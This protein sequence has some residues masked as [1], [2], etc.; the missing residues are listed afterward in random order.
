V[1]VDLPA[2][3]A[4]KD[5]T[6]KNCLNFLVEN[7][8]IRLQRFEQE[9]RQEE[10]MSTQLGA[11]CLASSL[12]PD[13]GIVVYKELQKARRCFV[14]ESDLHVLYQVTPIY[15]SDTLRDLSWLE[16]LNMWNDLGAGE[17]Y[18]GS[19]V[20][21]DEAFIFRAMTGTYSKRNSALAGRFSVHQR[22]YIALALND[23]V[24][25]MPITKVAEKYSLNKGLIQSLQQ[26]AS[27]FA[28]EIGLELRF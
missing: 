2:S 28:G 18:V 20:G 5:E 25:E 7:D 9:G 14:L 27:T 1:F 26:S 3:Q 4:N 6:I 16:Y 13:E 21:I 22:F 17:K 12:A 8:F 19:L 10:Y 15:L 24:N 23:L 11:A